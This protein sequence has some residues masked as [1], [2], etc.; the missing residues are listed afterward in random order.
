LEKKYFHD[1]ETVLAAY[2]LY[3]AYIGLRISE[4]YYLKTKKAGFPALNIIICL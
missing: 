1:R 2:S 4:K 3:P